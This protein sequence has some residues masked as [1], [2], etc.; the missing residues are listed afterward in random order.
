MELDLGSCRYLHFSLPGAGS[1]HDTNDI[2]AVSYQ[3]T[4]TCVARSTRS[5]EVSLYTRVVNVA[6]Q[7]V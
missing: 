6:T 1:S 7:R 2:E 4:H 5:L 3:A